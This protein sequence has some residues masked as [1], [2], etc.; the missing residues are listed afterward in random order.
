MTQKFVPSISTTVDP[1]TSDLASAR[2]K[3]RQNVA[4]DR[5]WFLLS[6][7]RVRLVQCLANDEDIHPPLT[8]RPSHCGSKQ[9]VAATFQ[10]LF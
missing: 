7:L 3:S 10:C 6:N 1:V 8:G 4:G 5:N 2:Q 9:A